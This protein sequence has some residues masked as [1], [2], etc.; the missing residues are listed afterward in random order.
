MQFYHALTCISG[1]DC[2]D[3]SAQFSNIAG[4]LPCLRTMLNERIK[5]QW[6]CSVEQFIEE[7]LNEN[8]DIFATVPSWRQ[9]TDCGSKAII[10]ICTKKTFANRFEKIPM[11]S[12]DESKIARSW[13]IITDRLI[14]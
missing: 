6:R 11:R 7:R 8:R 13:A 2:L 4:I 12:R 9:P 10:K 5:K 14:S 3:N 1:S